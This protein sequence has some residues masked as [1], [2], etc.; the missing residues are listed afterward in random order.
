MLLYFR[1]HLMFLDGKIE[2]FEY[3]IDIPTHTMRF[4]EDKNIGMSSW[5][6]PVFKLKLVREG[7]CFRAFINDADEQRCG[8]ENTQITGVEV[9]TDLILDKTAYTC[10]Y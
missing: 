4:M 8:F 6:K 9:D 3:F 7:T 2:V 1:F 5:K 10:V